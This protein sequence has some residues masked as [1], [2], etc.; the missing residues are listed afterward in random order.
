[1]TSVRVAPDRHWRY[2]DWVEL[3]GSY[4][5]RPEAAGQ[6]VTFFVDDE[7]LGRMSGLAPDEAAASLVKAIKEVLGDLDTTGAYV[8]ARAIT[9]TWEEDGSQGYIRCLPLLAVA[10]L[11]A[12]KMASEGTIRSYN[13]YVR[14]RDLVGATG[15]GQPDGYELMPDLWRAYERWLDSTLGGRLGHSTV[16][17]HRHFTLIGFALS[18]ALFRASDRY[19][20]THFLATLSGPVTPATPDDLLLA[21]LRDWAA[22]R[23]T[24]SRGAAQ[25]I[26]QDSF[27]TQ[28]LDI[29]RA[30]AAMWDG[31]IRDDS[32]RRQA[33]VLLRWNLEY[34]DPLA[35]IA[36]R[37][38]GFPPSLT[39]GS[40]P[41]SVVLRGSN[42]SRFY[43]PA[44]FDVESDVLLSG[45]TARSGDTGLSLRFHGNSIHL[46]GHID[47][48]PDWVSART[49]EPRAPHIVLV[50]TDRA[51][52]LAAALAEGAEPGWRQPRPS[53]LLPHDWVYAA[54][55]VPGPASAAAWERT[56]LG[57][58]GT[59]A[60][61]DARLVGGLPLRGNRV[62]LMGGE[63]DL[64]APSGLILLDDEALEVG[65]EG[66]LRLS[67]RGLPA[68]RHWIE[69]DGQRIRFGI[70]KGGATPDRQPRRPCLLELDDGATARGAALSH[71]PARRRSVVAIRRRR[72]TWILGKQPGEIVK[73]QPLAPPTVMSVGDRESRLHSPEAEFEVAFD[74][75]WSV[76][77]SG[78]GPPMI[79]SLA[80]VDPAPYTGPATEGVR[81][82]ARVFT[83]V[84]GTAPGLWARY[85]TVAE[86]IGSEA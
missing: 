6:P 62:Y 24:L 74:P 34:G 49:F 58:F 51:P 31:A 50:P 75:V 36:E 40:A 37:P 68:G 23:S 70:S 54:N 26:E 67:G 71:G 76:S 80:S 15:E 30:S 18:Q 27:R 82:W 20:L 29:V 14:Y 22:S 57:K 61:T 7:E 28:V 8:T 2:A 43:A 12:T 11:A 5:F 3:L 32:G 47:D 42:S 59:M 55:V 72:I 17:G 10:V 69:L 78:F 83:S 77:Y 19:E 81:A 53:G 63:P 73:A 86:S 38:E 46:L 21:A 79:R 39:L 45:G 41:A 64:R 84:P 13:Y 4:F 33:R 52:E 44:P 60:R 85:R 56:I 1:M 25:M 66:L 65:D 9:R 35:C 48:I 16:V